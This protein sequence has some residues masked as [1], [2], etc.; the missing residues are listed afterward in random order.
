MLWGTGGLL[1]KYVLLAHA[2]LWNMDDLRE[3]KAADGIW[4]LPGHRGRSSVISGEEYDLERSKGIAR[5]CT[6]SA[7]LIGLV[8]VALFFSDLYSGMKVGT[9]LLVFLI[10]ASIPA[11]FQIPMGISAVRQHPP[12]AEI[13]NDGPAC[14]AGVA[15]YVTTEMATVYRGVQPSQ[16]LLRTAKGFPFLAHGKEG[17]EDFEGELIPLEDMVFLHCGNGSIDVTGVAPQALMELLYGLDWFAPGVA[18]QPP[19][20]DPSMPYPERSLPWINAIM[21]HP[22]A[23]PSPFCKKLNSGSSTDDDDIDDED[24]LEYEP[25]AGES[26][27]MPANVSVLKQS[28]VFL[29]YRSLWDFALSQ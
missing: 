21:S 15:M 27:S 11:L 3:E 9:G 1:A 19:E 8:V 4:L 18:T 25:P 2:R 28:S 24:L 6:G 17:V 22:Q 29:R 20:Q 5:I 10:L 13:R 26:M 7:V 16:T 14:T 23:P 12:K